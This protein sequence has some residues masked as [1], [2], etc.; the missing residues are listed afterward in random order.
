MTVVPRTGL[1]PFERGVGCQW[2]RAQAAGRRHRG[3]R[4]GQ[5]LQHRMEGK[6]VR[7]EKAHPEFEVLQMNSECFT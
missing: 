2:G 6:W 7:C 5:A 3:S 4:W 1:V